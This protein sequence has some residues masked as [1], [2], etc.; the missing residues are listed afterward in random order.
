V[1]YRIGL[2]HT[3]S[4][5]EVR[6]GSLSDRSPA[7]QRHRARTSDAPGGTLH[8]AI[9]VRKQDLYGQHEVKMREQTQ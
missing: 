1:Q 5:R 6:Q 4:R 9:D 3:L 7:G 2:I 8:L